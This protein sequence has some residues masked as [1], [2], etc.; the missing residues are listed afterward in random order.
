MTQNED[1][2]NKKPLP[3]M[4]DIPLVQLVPLKTRKV[5]D[6][7]MRKIRASIEMCGIIEPFH[8]CQLSDGRYGIMNGYIRY[9]I[10]MELGVEMAPCF[11]FDVPDLYTANHQVNHLSPIEE[12]RMMK[13]ALEVVPEDRVAKVFGLKKVTLRLPPTLMAQLHPTIV[14]E[15]DHDRVPRACARE[16]ANVSPERQLA[17][18][19]VMQNANRYDVAFVKSQILKTPDSEK[20]QIR[21]YT[22]WQENR[23]RKKS[24]V[25]QLQETQD[26]HDFYSALYRQLTTDLMLAVIY[27]R[28]IITKDVLLKYLEM[29]E[30]NALET[31]LEII[32]EEVHEK[33]T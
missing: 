19:A 32:K 28:E 30:P 31:V 18:F 6:N 22:P 29:H 12:A 20:R 1:H 3:R 17:I 13:K 15:Y 10:L 2:S 23:D 27:A 7:T 11:V 25:V 21:K 24:L 4:E 9:L 5:D 8:V 33:K 26:E 14:Q 16:L